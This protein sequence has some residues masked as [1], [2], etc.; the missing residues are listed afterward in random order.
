M[1]FWGFFKP[2]F[3]ASPNSGILFNSTMTAQYY[4]PSPFPPFFVGSDKI[5]LQIMQITYQNCSISRDLSIGVISIWS[6]NNS[7]RKILCGRGS[8]NIEEKKV[9]KMAKKV[10]GFF[11]HKKLN[12]FFYIF[13]F[14]KPNA[15]GFIEKKKSHRFLDDLGS[16]RQFPV[17]PF[18]FW[19]IGCDTI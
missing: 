18:F 17:T 9:L 16:K 15:I 4:V 12:V 2:N 5:I 3:S 14:N 6:G 1:N 19:K 7:L 10:L 8:A 13:F 11:L